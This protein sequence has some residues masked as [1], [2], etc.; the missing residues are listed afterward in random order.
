M[1]TPTCQR[2]KG[3]G[4]VL[5]DVR[6]LGL[7]ESGTKLLTAGCSPVLDTE[8]R[9]VGHAM[10]CPQCNGESTMT[11]VRT[12]GQLYGPAMQIADQVEADRYFASLVEY[13]LAVAPRDSRERAEEVQRVNLGYFAG[14][15]DAETRGRVERLFRCAH[16][17]FGP[18]AQRGQPTPEEAFAAGMEAGRRLKGGGA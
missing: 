18:I 1:T 9:Y 7:G 15:Y 4:L 14:Y 5:A 2:C 6:R 16:P 12:Y 10:V 11:P 13:H 8:G 17:V 3:R